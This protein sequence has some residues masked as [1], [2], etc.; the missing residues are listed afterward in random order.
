VLTIR[1]PSRRAFFDLVSDPEYAPL[2]PYKLASLRV[3]LVPVAG[4]SVTPDW[5]WMIGLALLSIFLAVGW[6]RAAARGT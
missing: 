2:M 5:R 1:Y 6:L 3:A 4:E